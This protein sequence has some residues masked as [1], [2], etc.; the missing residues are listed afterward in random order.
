[1]ST[2]ATPGLALTLSSRELDAFVRDIYTAAILGGLI[3]L[4]SV[5]AGWE[6]H[7]VLA[8]HIAQIAMTKRAMRNEEGG[9]LQ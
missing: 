7:V 2:G 8:E 9:T 3:A 4:P 6:E 5:E 1:M